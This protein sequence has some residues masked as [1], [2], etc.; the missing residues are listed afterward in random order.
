MNTKNLIIDGTNIEYRIFFVEN[1]W[2]N[3]NI[4]TDTTT[5]VETIPRFLVTFKKLIQHFNPDNVYCAW[6]R[7]LEYPS[8]NFRDTLLN[9]AYKADRVKH[10]KVGD[11][12]DQEPLLREI[13]ATL[14]VKHF[15][16]NTLEADDIV[17]WLSKT[18]PDNSVIVTGDHDLYQAIN[19]HVSVWNLKQLITVDNFKQYAGVELKHYKLYKAIKKDSDN[20]AGIPGY[21]KVKAALLAQN[22]ENTTLTEDQK[23]IV[24]RNLKLIDLDYGV[25]NQ[26]G[27]LESYKSQFENIKSSYDFDTFLTLC[28]KHNLNEPLI[29][30]S[31]WRRLFK[32]NTLVDI[33]NQLNIK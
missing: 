32:R 3:H 21:G 24:E 17:Y 12:F 8:T 7:K 25:N 23:Q 9:G 28:R 13:L 2:K 27:E 20:I 1:S 10:E 18:V 26:P 29:N 19:D 15:F 6:D 4:E 31:E 33:I 30:T 11:M 22:F 5:R 16:P 14:G